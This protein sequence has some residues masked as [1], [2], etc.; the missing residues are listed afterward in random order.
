MS[1]QVAV[2]TGANKGI[3]LEIVRSLCRHFGQDGVV[4]LTARNEGRGLAAVELLQ[5][6]GL[7]PRFHLLDVTDQ[8]SIDTL[9]DHLEKEHGGLDVLINNAGIGTPKE[10]ISLSEKS[11]RVMNT[12]FFGLLNV[13]R[14]L[15]PLVRSCGRIVNM[16]STTGYMVFR[17]QINDEVRNR[18]RQVEEEQDVADLMNEFLE[19]CK[20]EC[21]TERGWCEWSYGVGKLGVILLSKI[22]ADRISQ[23]DSKH[24]I[25]LNSCCPGFVLT[26]MTSDLPD[27]NFGGIRVSTVEGADTPVF[28]A[29]LPS[30]ATEPNGKFLL[31]RK[32]YDFV[33]TDVLMQI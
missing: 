31:K 26:D 33:N 1:L 9:R 8:S 3:G 11:S 22:Q 15:F 19:C 12:N 5:K 28:L 32:E 27:N 16:A 18:F 10:N 4:Y 2:V 25:L 29:L 7:N 14:S 21:N 24:G 13:C 30:K 20:T 23:D 17:G 6:E